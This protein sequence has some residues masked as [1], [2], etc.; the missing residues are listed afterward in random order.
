MNE[1]KVALSLNKE[2]I[3]KLNSS[4]M[5]EVKGGQTALSMCPD[6]WCA[7]QTC[8]TICINTCAYTCVCSVGTG[9]CC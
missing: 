9:A 8:V 2:T 7:W 6:T 5:I 3:A 1:R 4:E